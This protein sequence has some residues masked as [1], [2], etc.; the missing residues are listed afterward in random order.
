M[1]FFLSPSDDPYYNQALE[2]YF[3]TQYPDGVLFCYINKPALVVGRFQVPYR[4]VDV[5]YMAANNIA[6]VRRLSGG[7]SVYHDGGNLNYS[8][9]TDC[10]DQTDDLYAIFNIKTLAILQQL[11]LAALSFERNNVFCHDKKISG[12]AQYK[13]G[14]RMVHHGTL[15]VD[16]DLLALRRL[17]TPKSYYLSKGVASISSSVGNVSDFLPVDMKAV[18]EVFR[19][20]CTHEIAK[21]PTGASIA[22]N[23]QM[24]AQKEWVLGKSPK[25]AI[26]HQGLETGLG[27]SIDKGRITSVTDDSLFPFVGMWHSYDVL[28]NK[29]VDTEH[30]VMM[31]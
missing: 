18:I 13:R 26:V 21:V 8:F 30:L 12:V 1:H 16:A 14:K 3:L 11:G 24:Y 22:A 20:T 15:L 5:P 25:Y 23:A 2:E 28:K 7:G 27:I 19:A 17:F 6:L 10:A 29:G 31:F 9:I 4:E